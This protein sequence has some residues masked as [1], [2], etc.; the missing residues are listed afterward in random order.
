MLVKYPP[1]SPSTSSLTT[2]QPPTIVYIIHH[3]LP[4]LHPPHEPIHA[5]LSWKCVLDWYPACIRIVAP[6]ALKVAIHL[7]VA[8]ETLVTTPTEHERV[9]PTMADHAPEEVQ[10]TNEDEVI[11]GGRLAGRSILKATRSIARQ[12]APGQVPAQRDEDPTDLA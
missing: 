10:Q 2:F 3:F 12:L 9:K 6:A 4:I 7:Q 11:L 5:L 1:S 8:V